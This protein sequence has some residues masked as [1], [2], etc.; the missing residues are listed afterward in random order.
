MKGET[1]LRL[2][3]NFLFLLLV[4]NNKVAQVINTSIYLHFLWLINKGMYYFNV[5][6]WCMNS[7]Q[8]IFLC[9]LLCLCFSGY[10]YNVTPYMEYHP[11]GIPELVRGIGQDATELF[12]EVCS[13]YLISSRLILFDIIILIPFYYLLCKL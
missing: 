5:L 2:I 4:L 11:G 8:Y 10:V 7:F 9:W 3:T 1:L 6:Q 13:Y 12:D